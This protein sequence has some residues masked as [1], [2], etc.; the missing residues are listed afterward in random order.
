MKIVLE[1]LLRSIVD[2]GIKEGAEFAEIKTQDTTGIYVRVVDGEIRNLVNR[3]DIGAGIR[4]FRGGAW[5]YSSTNNLDKQSLLE[6]LKNA[7]SLMNAAEKNTE[8]RFKLNPP[9]PFTK[10]SQMPVKKKLTDVQVED[11]INYTIEANNAAKNTDSRIVSA[12]TV[13]ADGLGVTRVCNSIGTYVE[14]ELSSVTA[15]AV[16]YAYE[17]GVR[18]EG[19]YSIGGTGGFEHIESEEAKNIGNRAADKALKLLNAKPA[20]AG[21]FRCI[22]DPYLAGL[23]IHEA[24][25]H[26]CEADAVLSG[27]SVL[28]GKMNKQ[29][30]VNEINVVDDPTIQ[31]LYGSYQYD[32]EGT[33]A[34]KK[35]LVKNGVLNEFLHSI[36]TS[37]RMASEANGSARAVEYRM[38][39]IVR[40]S[41]TYIAPGDWEFEEMLEDM[42]DGI[43]A[44]GLNYGYTDP[45]NGQ[46]TF[47]CEEAYII[48]NGKTSTMLRD[49]AF[50]GMILDILNNIDAI[51]KDI[52]YAPGMC[53]KGAQTIRTTTG[54]PHIRI[55]DIVFGGVV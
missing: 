39:P 18:S 1:E 29:V 24:F 11:K 19:H 8:M 51:G 20:S 37:S 31:G 6:A 16:A 12:S 32:S 47:K 49:A 55:N 10:N 48:E 7:L 5:G 4:V 15:A 30:G 13:Y 28:E 2:Q 17:Q 33:P 42:K 26:A 14:T 43:Y 38:Q 22:F 44:K 21:K 34:R 46:F 25:G 23:L 54:G 50:T 52:K 40:M 35:T 27:E 9:G 53:G 3:G 36:E 41:N 45:S